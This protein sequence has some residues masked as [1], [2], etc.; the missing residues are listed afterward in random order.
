LPREVFFGIWILI[1]AGLFAY[2]IGWLKF[3]HDDPAQKIS[4]M[5]KGFALLV[6]AFTI[7]L[8][9]GV[10]NTKMANLSIVSGFPPPHCYS[11]FSSPV[12][13]EKPLTDYDEALALAKKTG[14]PIMIDFTGWACVNCRK[15]EENVWPDARVKELMEKYIL[16]SLY[17]DDKEK[18]PISRQFVFQGKDSLE[19]RIITVGDKWSAFQAEN[20][21]ASSQPW[22]VL[23]SPDEKLLTPPVGYTPDKEVYASWLECGLDAFKSTSSK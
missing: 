23:L 18:L 13:C 17:V 7:Y 2:L 19:K 12:N 15:M 9:P 8:L 16:V 14:K 6:L 11:L 10:T 5:R 22:Y 21:N 20:F 4:L 3:P 1:G